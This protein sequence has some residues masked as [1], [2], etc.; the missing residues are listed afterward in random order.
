MIYDF[1]VVGGGAAGL[2]AAA[3]AAQKGMK[4]VVLE[5]N[6]RFARKVMITGKGRCNV[7]N[8]T[9]PQKLMENIPRNPKFMYSAFAACD[10]QNVMQF[11]EQHGLALKTER[12]NRVFP[13]SDKAVDVVDT[14][15]SAC[16]EAKVKLLP[17]KTVAALC[18]TDGEIK[19][20]K[21]AS[22]EVFEAQRVLVTCGGLSY[23]TTGSTGDGYTLARQVGHTITP[24]RGSL[25]ALESDEPLCKNAMGLS[26]KNVTLTCYEKGKKKDKAV[27]F[28]MGEMLFTHFGVSGPLV[29][30]ASAHM[31]KDPREYVL[32][33]DL[34]PALSMEQLDARI[35]R[36]FSKY[37]NKDIA[38]ALQE[39]LPKKLISDI[40]RLSGIDVQTKVHDITREQRMALL[41]V[42]KKLPI[43]IA[44]FRPVAEAIITSGGVSVKEINPHTMESKLQKGLYFAGEVIDVD[45][46]TGGFNLQIAFSTGYLAAIS[47]HK[48][49]IW[50]SGI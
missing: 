46:Y 42:I 40:I 9:T 12:G 34:K 27:Y 22:G 6:P 4:V 20:V 37:I 17:D 14:L 7:T 39:L 35:L 18:V 13:V 25:T 24:C 43:P 26:L 28:E 11:F 47:A 29:L 21:T 16:K 33:I 36:D 8:N 49:W 1:L 23:P 10:A 5:K 41:G 45:A 48:A 30:S 50:E 38:N 2:Y 32:C 31:K 3:C 19:G 44:D 15:V